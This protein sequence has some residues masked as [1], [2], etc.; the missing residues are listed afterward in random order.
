MYLWLD[1]IF[2]NHIQEHAFLELS[3]DHLCV[4]SW[5]NCNKPTDEWADYKRHDE[6]TSGFTAFK[7]RVYYYLNRVYTTTGGLD[8]KFTEP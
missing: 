6:Y 3:R 5:R 2:I 7:W 1:Q 8:S 4:S